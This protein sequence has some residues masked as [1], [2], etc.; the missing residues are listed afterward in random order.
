MHSVLKKFQVNNQTLNIIAQLSFHCHNLFYIMKY[1]Y[2]QFSIVKNTQEYSCRINIS[3]PERS[4]SY[5]QDPRFFNSMRN[6]IQ[7]IV[8]NNTLNNKTGSI[9]YRK[10][11][12]NQIIQL[13]VIVIQ[14]ANTRSCSGSKFRIEGSKEMKQKYLINRASKRWIG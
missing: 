1:E 3:R 13:I 2:S 6:V 9:T 5:M 10:E 8:Y 14:P 7:F 12:N 4:K 11:L